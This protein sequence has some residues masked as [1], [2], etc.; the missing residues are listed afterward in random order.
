VS[1]RRS[2][3]YS[4]A[5]AAMLF[6]GV[7]SAN[8][9]G[10]P[11]AG[12]TLQEL[13]PPPQLAPPPPLPVPEARPTPAPKPAPADG[14]TFVLRAVRFNGN[15]A[16]SSAELADLMRDKIGRSVSFGDLSALARRITDHYRA[17]GYPLAVGI[18]PRQEIPDGSVQFSVI[19]GKLGRIEVNRTPDTPVSDERLRAT[20]ERALPP[21]EPVTQRHLERAMLLASDLPG[22]VV[23]GALEA[24][25]ASGTTDLA[26][27][28]TK[29]R[30]WDLTV[31]ADNYGARATGEERIG[32]LGRIN[33]P[34][35]FGDNLDLRLMESNGHGIGYARLAYEAPAGYLGTRAGIA[36]SRLTYA[37]G[38][39][40]AGLDGTGDATVTSLFVTHPFLR[41][42][43][44]NVVV[45]LEL[46]HKS[47]EDRTRFDFAPKQSNTLTAGIGWERRDDFMRGGY[48]S[49]NATATLGRL[50]LGADAAARDDI[51]SGGRGTAGGFAHLNLQAG[52]LQGLSANSSVYLAFAAQ[53]ANGNLDSS[54]RIALGGPFGVRA[55]P[56]SEG[57]ADEGA[58]FNAEY[59][60]GWGPSTVLS[61]FYDYGWGRL[62]HTALTA[63]ASGL[64]NPN[65]CPGGA[66][67][68]TCNLR[69]A[70]LGI[71][72]S[73][74]NLFSLRA[75]VAWRLGDPALS[76]RHDRDP[77]LY[78]Q[79]SKTF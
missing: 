61:A 59:R 45:R 23:Q 4:L 48:T 35:G 43:R 30:R 70:G 28:A 56:T 1:R 32:A 15:S 29:A 5:L 58:I 40:F 65:A 66:E 73:P 64:N 74:R 10:R 60:Y 16:F 76:D 11:D 19:E 33:S 39:D 79:V 42:R 36:W 69:G 37:L 17:H 44:E 18:L 53:A 67:V 27:D 49:V 55:Y 20:L 75:T 38:S 72:L 6:A 13:S 3:A 14:V 24:G 34:F 77:R 47:L 62:N 78:L 2:A 57:I 21:G 8:A 25:T 7:G 31:D 71:S 9:Q 22:V 26:V 51:G 46:D 41:S 68:N 63:G 50:S 52:R 54:E 12:S